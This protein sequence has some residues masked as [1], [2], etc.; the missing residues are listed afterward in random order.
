M[1]PAW[2]WR[3]CVGLELGEALT[4]LQ[5]DPVGGF[6]GLAGFLIGVVAVGLAV[7]YG[8][9]QITRRRRAGDSA[10]KVSA[11]GV[12]PLGAAMLTGLYSGLAST[13]ARWST[14]LWV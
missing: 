9:G 7:G 12:G 14:E 2:A 13:F 4:T 1:G 6:L 11:V 5:T 8:I 10:P 3:P